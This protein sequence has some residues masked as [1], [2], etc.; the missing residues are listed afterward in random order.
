MLWIL[1]H[2]H[3]VRGGETVH[4]EASS[5]EKA[6]CVAEAYCKRENLKFVCVNPFAV[7]DESILDGDQKDV[8][9]YSLLSI[10]DVKQAVIGGIISKKDALIWEREGK[11]RRS[12]IGWLEE[13]QTVQTVSAA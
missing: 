13:L 12:L 11:R 6:E 3:P 7:A 2:R 10:P 8:L 9:D 5:L 4:I 1:T